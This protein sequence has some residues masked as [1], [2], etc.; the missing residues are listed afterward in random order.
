ML[1]DE[2]T[3]SGVPSPEAYQQAR[4]AAN[5]ADWHSTGIHNSGDY[6]KQLFQ[7][8]GGVR[9][10]PTKPQADVVTDK[11][12]AEVPKRQK[13]N[14]WKCRHRHEARKKVSHAP[15]PHDKMR[16]NMICTQCF[17]ADRIWP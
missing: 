13:L 10:N 7:D 16:A 5:Y 1:S 2:A 14:L 4:E 12:D 15:L 17:P 9:F 3:E 11:E 6:L 8:E